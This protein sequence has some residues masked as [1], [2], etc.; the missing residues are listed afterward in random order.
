MA[1]AFILYI[2]VFELIK[3]KILEVRAK[4][5]AQKHARTYCKR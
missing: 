4:R 2:V 5:Y 3:E 1:L